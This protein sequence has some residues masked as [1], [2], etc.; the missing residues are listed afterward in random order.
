M[1][2]KI[3]TLISWERNIIFLWNKKALTCASDDTIQEIT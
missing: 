3:K 2:E 1:A